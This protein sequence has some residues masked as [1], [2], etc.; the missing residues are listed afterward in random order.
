MLIRKEKKRMAKISE[1]AKSINKAWKSDVLT[2]GDLIPDC[3]RFS[4]GALSADYALYGGLPEGK[5]IVYAGESGS[6]K[7]WYQ[8]YQLYNGKGTEERNQI[9]LDSSCI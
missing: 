4:M 2:S 8:R 5:L 1:I 6:C 3:V 7:G 9:L